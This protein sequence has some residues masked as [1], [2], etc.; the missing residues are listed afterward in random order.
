MPSL[1]QTVSLWVHD[2]R[3]QHVSKGIAEQGIWESYETQLFIERLKPGINVID[4]GANIGY[5]SVIA[6]DQLA[7]TGFIAAFEPDPD[8]YQLLQ[9]NLQHNQFTDVDAVNAGLSAKDS[10]GRLFLSCSNFGDH[11]IYDAGEGRAS[12]SIRLI[13][14][15]N[16]LQAK[17]Q[18]I[19][20]LKIDTQGA[21]S[22]VIAGLLPLLKN[23]GVKLSMIIE[24]WPY[25]LRQSGSSAHQLVDM[26]STLDLPIK[27]IDHIG[28]DLVDCTEQQLREW[29]DMVETNPQDQGFMNIL[30][31]K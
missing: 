5:Y 18:H 15:A 22:E 9:K 28:H 27:I 30:L 4:V 17:I 11:Q 12:R 29:V 10:D 6:A 31:G 26:L 16:Y 1:H 24:F 7:G 14:G 13:N 2:Q 21:E 3:D 8:N 19:D 25:G 23:S 20:L